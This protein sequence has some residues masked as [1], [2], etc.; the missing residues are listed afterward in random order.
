LSFILIFLSLKINTYLASKVLVMYAK[1]LRTF[2]NICKKLYF[3]IK[4]ILR[5]DKSKRIA[6]LAENKNQQ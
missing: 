2:Q 6:R 3:A 1:Y 4:N 5:K